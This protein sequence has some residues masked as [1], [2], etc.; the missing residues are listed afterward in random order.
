MT[1][2]SM[3]FTMM[4]TSS[5]PAGTGTTSSMMMPTT[6]MGTAN[7]L[8]FLSIV[9]SGGRRGGARSGCLELAVLL[10]HPG[11]RVVHWR[12]IRVWHGVHAAGGGA[13]CLKRHDEGEHPGDGCVQL[14][15]D[16]VA[17]LAGGVQGAGEGNVFHDRYLVGFGLLANAGRDL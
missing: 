2:A 6:P 7:L 14:S 10:A 12:G 5:T 11:G 16:L 1:S 4:S 13:A 3:M 8:R 9:S 15:R 17:E